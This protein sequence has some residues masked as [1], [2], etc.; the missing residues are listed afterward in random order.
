MAAGEIDVK[1]QGERAP[2]DDLVLRKLGHRDV[3]CLAGM[4]LRGVECDAL[5]GSLGLHGAQL[6]FAVAW[7]EVRL[8]GH[9]VYIH[10]VL[11]VFVFFCFLFVFVFLY[12]CVLKF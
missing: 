9:R 8:H 7:K 1:D 3:Q 2:D 4:G 5:D 6:L 12:L 11:F 10:I